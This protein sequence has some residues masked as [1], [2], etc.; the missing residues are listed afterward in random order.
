MYGFFCLYV[1]KCFLIKFITNNCTSFTMDDAMSMFRSRRQMW[2]FILDTAQDT[3]AIF[4]C[5]P[6]FRVVIGLD[7]STVCSQLIFNRK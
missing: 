7:T 5:R 6:A 4:S 1:Y 3:V 2:L